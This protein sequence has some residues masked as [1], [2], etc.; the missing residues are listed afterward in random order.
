MIQGLWS[1]S[2]TERYKDDLRGIFGNIT[3]LPAYQQELLE[4]TFFALQRDPYHTGTPV[5]NTRIPYVTWTL[6][7]IEGRIKI[8]FFV[9]GRQ[10][11]LAGA[12]HS[13]NK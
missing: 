4:A 11:F 7:M 13:V 2:E 6:P 5:M 1:V 12:T 10:A 8:F 3:L 9:E